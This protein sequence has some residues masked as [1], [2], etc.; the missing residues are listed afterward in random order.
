MIQIKFKHPENSSSSQPIVVVEMNLESVENIQQAITILKQ[1]KRIY[2][3]LLSKQEE[4]KTSL[5]DD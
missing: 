3:L 2:R 5:S 4:E 1:V